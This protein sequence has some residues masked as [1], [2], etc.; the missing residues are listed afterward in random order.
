MVQ[1]NNT[2]KKNMVKKDIQV[3]LI[4]LHKYSSGN[5][6]WPSL[7]SVSTQIYKENQDMHTD[8]Y[9]HELERGG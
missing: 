3:Y 8:T 4:I 2:Y 5:L 6:Y 9:M 1:S 7:F